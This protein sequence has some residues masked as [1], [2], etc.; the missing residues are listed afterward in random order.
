[1]ATQA[2]PCTLSGGHPC[3]TLAVCSARAALGWIAWICWLPVSVTAPASM[4]F[5]D[6]LMVLVMLV[7]TCG[8]AVTVCAVCEMG[9]R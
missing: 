7:F 2:G 6:A 5:I 1:M 8:A 9:Q 4:R 3:A